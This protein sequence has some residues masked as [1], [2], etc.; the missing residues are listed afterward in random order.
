MRLNSQIV[1]HLIGKNALY[2][3]SSRVSSLAF[4]GIVWQRK[5]SLFFFK[6]LL[7]NNKIVTIWQKENKMKWIHAWKGDWSC[8]LFW[9]DLE[10]FE[11]CHFPPCWCMIWQSLGLKA[12]NW[13]YIS[14]NIHSTTVFQKFGSLTMI[15]LIIETSLASYH[16]GDVNLTLCGRVRAD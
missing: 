15:C 9:A 3:C 4:L 11:T 2:K 5:Y 10:L 1:T 6:Q 7:Y 13:C 16:A 12:V 8:R 14:A